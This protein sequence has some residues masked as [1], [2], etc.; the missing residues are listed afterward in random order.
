MFGTSLTKHSLSL[1][2]RKVFVANLSF[3][4]TSDSLWTHFDQVAT[5]LDA[6]VKIGQDGRSRGQ[7][8]VTYASVED[9]EEAIRVLHDSELDGRSIL[10]KFDAPPLDREGKGTRAG[11]G[12]GG[13][14][15]NRG[16]KGDRSGKGD[17]GGK[18]NSG[19][20]GGREK[21]ASATELDAEMDSYFNRSAT[22][23]ESPPAKGTKG[24]RGGIAKSVPEASAL[25]SEMDAYFAASKKGASE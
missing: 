22:T 23:A 16:G 4:T 15:G 11:K 6:F 7:G 2:F 10:V 21:Q 12:E 25:D 20:K 1:M 9:A 8:I 18:G 19:G 3:G 24:S 14:K 17:R 5:V 13:G